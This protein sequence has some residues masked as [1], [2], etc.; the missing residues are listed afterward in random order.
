MCLFSQLIHANALTYEDINSD[1]IK[2]R[3][4][5]YHQNPRQYHNHYDAI[6]NSVS[7]M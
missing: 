5:L 3:I 1:K 7:S 4:H 2:L 6:S